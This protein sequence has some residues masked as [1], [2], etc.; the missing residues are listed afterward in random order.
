VQQILNLIG[1]VSKSIL[2]KHK[3][4]ANDMETSQRLAMY[5]EVPIEFKLILDP[6]FPDDMVPQILGVVDA[7]ALGRGMPIN[8]P[9]DNVKTA[10]GDGNGS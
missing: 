2:F 8:E 7:Q 9:I 3:T 1:V 6:L 5:S 10:A 4:I